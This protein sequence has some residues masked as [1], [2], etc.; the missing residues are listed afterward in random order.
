MGLIVG[1]L[2]DFAGMCCNLFLWKSFTCFTPWAMS[3]LFLFAILAILCFNSMM[4][5][6][7]TMG[8]VTIKVLMNW[9]ERIK[10]VYKENRTDTK[11]FI[12]QERQEDN[13]EIEKA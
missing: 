13:D 9:N 11:K 7:T 12:V 3:L 6:N 2:V 8:D 4:L 5:L 1:V 10:R